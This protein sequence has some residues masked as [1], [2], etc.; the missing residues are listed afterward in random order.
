[1]EIGLREIRFV[2]INPSQMRLVKIYG[3]QIWLEGLDIRIGSPPGIPKDVPGGE[4]A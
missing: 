4:N 2:E 3:M 1:M